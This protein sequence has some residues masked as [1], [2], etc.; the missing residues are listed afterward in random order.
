MSEHMNQDR[1]QATLFFIISNVAYLL[2]FLIVS[3]SIGFSKNL[4]MIIN[5]IFFVIYILNLWQTGIDTYGFYSKKYF[6][7]DMLSVA[8][9]ACIPSL[10][11]KELSNKDFV[12]MSL[13]I[14]SINESICVFWDWLCHQNSPN[15]D[16]KMFH[17]K[18]SIFTF[19]GILL[20]IVFTGLIFL[21]DKLNNPFWLILFNS[22]CILYQIIML[23]IWRVAEYSLIKKQS[24]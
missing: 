17:Y 7:A 13:I 10:Y 16:G 14:I 9:Y 3:V 22:I 5:G 4:L 8:T 2:I 11:I 6:V 12:C 19:I 24:T 21:L 18:W 1:I 20:N 15:N 23:V